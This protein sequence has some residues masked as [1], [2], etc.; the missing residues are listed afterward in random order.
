MQRN[1]STVHHVELTRRQALTL[2]VAAVGAAAGAFGSACEAESAPSSAPASKAPA[3]PSVPATTM[4]DDQHQLLMRPGKERIAIV[5]YPQFT[6]LD[7]IGP[8]HVFINMVGAKVHLVAATMDPVP[9]DTGFAIVPT[10]TFEEIKDPQTLVLVPGGTSGTLAAMQDAATMD[11]LR[12]Q[13]AQA[14]WV[15][16]VCTGSLLLAAAGLLDGY[17]ATSHWLAR[18]SLRAGGA[19]PTAERFVEDRNR[20]TGA[21][22]AAGLDF[23]LHLVRK[24]RGDTY[25]K[26]VQMFMEYDPQPPFQ[27]GSPTS[28]DAEPAM[29]GMLTAMHAPF[30]PKCEAAIREA[31]AARR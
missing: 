24:W 11:F 30:G 26:G 4:S 15:G 25:A 3:P 13:G 2:G 20:V 8:H 28:R 14:E 7:A 21:G 31:R 5:L 9:T 19:I 27:S 17:R 23:A 22:V 16:S 10:A 6:A 29:V 12:R 1:H 18:E